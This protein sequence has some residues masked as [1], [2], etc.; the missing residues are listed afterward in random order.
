MTCITIQE[1]LCI[2]IY[3]M[4]CDDFQSFDPIVPFDLLCSKTTQ[5]EQIISKRVKYFH[6][7][8]FY[9]LD[10]LLTWKC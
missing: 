5:T 2:T 1:M 8:S 3:K 6:I 9:N 10:E 4:T 7:Y